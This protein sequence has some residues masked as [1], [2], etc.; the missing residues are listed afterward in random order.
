MKQTS[1]EAP[2]LTALLNINTDLCLLHA[3]LVMT[4]KYVLE[5]TVLWELIGTRNFLRCFLERFLKSPEV[6]GK[7]LL[8][9]PCAIAYNAVDFESPP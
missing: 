3:N 8:K 5:C 7:L 4:H 6:C 2:L 1:L 9:F